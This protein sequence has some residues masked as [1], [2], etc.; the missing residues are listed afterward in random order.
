M[1][2]GLQ[3]PHFRPSTPE[4]RREW[5]TNTAQTIEAGGFYSV[6]VMDHFHQ[7]GGWLGDP[8]TEMM[9]GY[10]T[11]GFLAGVTEKIKLG[12]MVG[13]VIYRHPAIVVKMISTL[14]VLS[15]GR[16]YFGIGAAWYEGECKAL[17][18][19]FPPKK[20]RFELL[21]E[22]LQ[23]AHKMF[24][25][26]ETPY[27]GK[28]TQ[29]EKPVNNPQ[30]LQ[31][32]HPPILIGGMGPKKTLR[33]VA[34]YADACNFFGG[35]EDEHILESLEILKGHCQDVGRPYGEIEKTVL[36]TI[37]MKGEGPDPIER[38]KQLHG[39]GFDQVIFNIDGEYSP[40][41]LSYLTQEV[42]PALTAL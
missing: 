38:G 19:P 12:L 41:T 5:L 20:T 4:N 27:T 23:I 13:G 6:W 30:P 1:R 9:E 18:L 40:D 21:E 17:G 37:S 25:G 24:A 7:L 28:H 15:G 3:I 32:P 11:L 35:R 14:D 10:T 26:E 33:Y 36:Q 39:W 31:K 22:Q 42:A 2:L 29:M 8:D 34:Q 16:M